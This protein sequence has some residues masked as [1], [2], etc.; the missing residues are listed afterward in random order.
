MNKRDLPDEYRHQ[1]ETL[2]DARPVCNLGNGKVAVK[3][4][5]VGM[6]GLMGTIIVDAKAILVALKEG[7]W[8]ED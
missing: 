5:L 8:S 7:L 3:G 4:E 1:C 2:S 6:D